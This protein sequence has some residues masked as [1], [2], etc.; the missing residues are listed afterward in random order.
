MSRAYNPYLVV[1]GSHKAARGGEV[2][3]VAP[4]SDLSEKLFLR[5]SFLF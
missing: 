3:L 4:L 1:L 5:Y 2:E